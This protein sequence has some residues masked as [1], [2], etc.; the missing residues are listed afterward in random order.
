G[1]GGAFA[2]PAS[3]YLGEVGSSFRRAI[4]K[5]QSSEVVGGGLPDGDV[6]CSSEE[7]LV[8]LKRTK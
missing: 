3:G 1:G 7:R 6:W 4:G 2:V 8:V 5:K